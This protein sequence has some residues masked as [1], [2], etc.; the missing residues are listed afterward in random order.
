MQPLISNLGH[1]LIQVG[2]YWIIGLVIGSLVSVY[3]SQRIVGQVGR[4]QSSSAALAL[5]PERGFYSDKTSLISD[6]RRSEPSL[7]GFAAL[8]MASILGAASPICMYGTIPLIAALGKKGIS[9]AILVSFMV[10]SIL[11][12]PNVFLMTFALGPSQAIWRLSLC[13]A[14]GCLA[15]HLVWKGEEQKKIF[16]FEKFETRDY[17]HDKTFLRDLA[18]AARITGPYFAVVLLITSLLE[19]YIPKSWISLMF[20]V[21]KSFEVGLATVLSIPVYTCDGAMIPLLRSWRELG[22][23]EGSAA[24]FMFA[25]AATKLGSLGA[26]TIILGCRNFALYI[27]YMLFFALISGLFINL[28]W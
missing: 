16:N 28:I 20:S 15:G 11:L 10:S 4:L 27:G 18:K 8:L 14:A 1:Q 6:Q 2:P 9:Q 23:S 19:V 21:D 12:N 7:N 26:M 5:R 13:L 17:R 22:L 24:A 3:L 25:G